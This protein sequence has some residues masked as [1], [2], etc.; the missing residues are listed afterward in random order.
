MHYNYTG[1][2]PGKDIVR[3][4]KMYYIDIGKF[5]KIDIILMSN[6]PAEIFLK[7]IYFWF[8]LNNK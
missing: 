7:W 8:K 5:N 6:N 1:C 2:L 4:T 3:Y